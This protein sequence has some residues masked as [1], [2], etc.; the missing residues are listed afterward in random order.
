MQGAVA[1]FGR[2]QVNKVLRDAFHKAGDY[3]GRHFLGKRFTVAGAKEYMF[4][5]RKAERARAG[6]KRFQ[7]YAGPAEKRAGKMLPF[8]YGGELRWGSQAYRVTAKATSKRVYAHVRLP[9]A[10]ALNKMTIEHRREFYTISKREMYVLAELINRE[11]LQ[12]LK[13]LSATEKT[14]RREEW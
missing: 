2:R 1:A 4:T 13:A 3:W 10:Q 7:Q 9:N 6:S 12:G 14:T 8:V 11:I 5:P